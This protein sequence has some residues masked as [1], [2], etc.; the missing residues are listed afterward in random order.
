MAFDIGEFLSDITKHGVSKPSQFDVVFTRPSKFSGP[1]F[2]AEHL[3]FRC[4]TAELPGRQVATTPYRIY[5][6]THP[7]AYNHTNLPI[8]LTFLCSEFL[9]EK[10]YFESWIEYIAGL[11]SNKPDDTPRMNAQYYD[12]YV[13]DMEIHQFQMN[14]NTK[15]YSAKF[16]EIFPTN[17]LPLTLDRKLQN[18]VH[19]VQV[20][21]A[22]KRWARI[23]HKDVGIALSGRQTPEAPGTGT[24][25]ERHSRGSG[26]SMDD[27]ER[28]N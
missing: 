28:W 26:K 6:A 14:Q 5:G 4:E 3:S 15:I 18:E 7:V 16:I 11:T 2:S 20:T 12:N 21:F 1:P 25:M 22:Y 24:I 8:N 13:A 27:W 23:P 19:K 17:V 9:S 10:V